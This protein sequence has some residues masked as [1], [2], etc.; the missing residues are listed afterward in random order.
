M[1]WRSHRIVTGI[2]VFAC[3]QSLL[4]TFAAIR[5]STFPDNLE[6][7]LPMKHRGASHWFPCYLLPMLIL[8]VCYK[9][10]PLTLF[11]NDLIAIVATP[12]PSIFIPAILRSLLFWFL[13]GSLFHILEDTLT[14]YVPILSPSDQRQWWHP[15]YTGSLK[16]DFFVLV[17]TLGLGGLLILRYSLTNKFSF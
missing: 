7:K 5:G 6:L 17:Y 11:T 2:T 8:A 4:A 1:I 14:G 10:F 15:F 12:D 13:A 3:T 9:D 16:E